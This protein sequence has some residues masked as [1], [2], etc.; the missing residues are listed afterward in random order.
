MGVPLN[1]QL[2]PKKMVDMK[3]GGAEVFL[4][5]ASIAQF[6]FDFEKEGIR[7]FRRAISFYLDTK[8]L[9]STT[10]G[11]G[12]ARQ[13]SYEQFF[14]GNLKIDAPPPPLMWWIPI[15]WGSG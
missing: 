2:T 4:E 7:L 8:K 5:I 15:F 14:R 3:I 9:V 6:F 1:F 10:L 11:G 12:R 13:F